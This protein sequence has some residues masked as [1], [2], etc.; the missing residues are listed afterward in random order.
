MSTPIADTLNSRPNKPPATTIGRNA[1]YLNSGGEALF[2]WLHQP[3]NACSSGH[4]VLI[5]PPIGYE[6]ID[7]HR[8]LR[9]LADDVA[10]AG[11]CVLRFDFHGTG[12]SAGTDENS[13]RVATWLANIHDAISW[14]ENELGCEQIT[15]FGL[16]LGATLA[17]QVAAD[18]AVENLLLW[19][20][21][22]KGRL[23][24]SEM[25]M[26]GRMVV[27]KP[28]SLP[29]APDNIEA[30][31]FVLTKQTVADLSKLDLLA[32]QPKCRRALIVAREDLAPDTRLVDHWLARGIQAEQIVQPG[33]AGMMA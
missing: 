5:C 3:E 13:D 8:S 6:Q 23:F 31:G 11:L 1:F 20:P 24:V 15:L 2:A 14:M 28:P 21:V 19:A 7:S 26:L 18:H 16:R 12:D 9:H 17:V 33:Y 10:R 29:E 32:I 4:G 27:N 25:K 22:T 30:A